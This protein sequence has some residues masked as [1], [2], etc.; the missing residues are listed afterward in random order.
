[1]YYQNLILSIISI[2]HHIIPIIVNIGPITG[3][4]D[5]KSEAINLSNIPTLNHRY[6][7]FLI[8]LINPL[9]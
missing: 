5:A 7:M 4:K 3:I 6:L 8:K 1:M 9:F 2:I